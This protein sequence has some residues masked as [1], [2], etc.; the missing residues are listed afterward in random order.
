MDKKKIAERIFFILIGVSAA[1]VISIG[2]AAIVLRESGKKSLQAD[3]TE[4]TVHSVELE[5][6][7]TVSKIENDDDTVM[8][9]GKKYRYNKDVVTILFMGIDNN[10]RYYCIY[11]TNRGS[12]RKGRTYESMHSEL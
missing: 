9:K 5:K 8:Y 3:E 12:A 1:L 10:D 4:I 7:A 2:V 11:L 6:K